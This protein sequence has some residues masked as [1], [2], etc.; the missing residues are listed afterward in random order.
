MGEI[1]K[2]ADNH[3]D[4]EEAIV[5]KKVMDDKDD[6]EREQNGGQNDQK[7]SRQTERRRA[8]GWYPA[9]QTWH[10]IP[11]NDRLSQ[12]YDEVKGLNM[13]SS[14]SPRTTPMG[15]DESAHC[16]FHKTTSHYMDDCLDL[17]RLIEELIWRGQLR[18]YVA[19]EGKNR[20]AANE[21]RKCVHPNRDR[22]RKNKN[23]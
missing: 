23:P 17:K 20:Q 6:N 21:R 15:H 16:K 22:T 19:R 7:L 9:C 2:R 10:F 18:K 5:S 3:I 14:P 1:R 12:I 11:V 13:I 4:T 8:P